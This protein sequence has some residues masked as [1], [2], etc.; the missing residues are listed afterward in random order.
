MLAVPTIYCVGAALFCLSVGLLSAYYATYTCCVKAAYFFR[1]QMMQTAPF[2]KKLHIFELLC[3]ALFL[4]IRNFA[5][6]PFPYPL[7]S[8]TEKVRRGRTYPKSKEHH[9]NGINF[10]IK[11]RTAM[12]F[13]ITA[14]FVD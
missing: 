12:L 4:A 13:S 2:R 3:Q 5:Y 7:S 6:F 14:F 10:F 11:K 9:T 8:L 1:W